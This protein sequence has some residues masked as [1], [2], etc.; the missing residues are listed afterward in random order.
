MQG[1]SVLAMVRGRCCQV[2]LGV[3][4]AMVVSLFV[5]GTAEATVTHTFSGA[6]SDETDPDDLT[7][8]VN[9]TAGTNLE[10]DIS[11]LS[12]FSIAQLYFNAN[13]TIGSLAFDSG[14]SPNANW[15][16]T[17][18]PSNNTKADGFGTF[19][20][21]IDFGSGSDRLLGGTTNLILDMATSASAEA[22][23]TAI[24]TTLSV[25]PPPD[26][27]AFA[28]LKFEAGPGGDSAFGSTVGDGDSSGNPIPEPSTLM[29]FIIGIFGVVGY[30][31]RRRKPL[32]R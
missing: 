10:I 2:A 18:G 19:E 28:A 31:W 5:S 16:I 24:K 13:G 17:Q 8:A 29:L 22:I 11:N 20:W 9:F 7:A 27:L 21:L 25:P 32:T 26:N 15:S 6:S 4:L 12:L 3:V 1:T 30:A 23:E 14:S